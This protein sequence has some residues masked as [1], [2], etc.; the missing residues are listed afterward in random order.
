MP[1]RSLPIVLLVEND[2]SLAR[3]WKRTLQRVAHCLIATNIE[4][5]EVLFAN[6]PT[7]C[8][9]VMDGCL[10]GRHL[11]TLDLIRTLRK[12]FTGPMIATSS[13]PYFCDQ[14]CHAGCNYRINVGLDVPKLDL[15]IIVNRLLVE[16]KSG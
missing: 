8:L 11:N 4:E 1:H 9:I 7:I 5:A 6:H 14:M 2:P 10:G 3:A 13:V 16:M 12:T 15:P